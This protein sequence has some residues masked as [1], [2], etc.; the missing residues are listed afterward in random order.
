M[1]NLIFIVNHL[2]KGEGGS[3]LNI[4]LLYPL[5]WGEEF[6]SDHHSHP[7]RRKMHKFDLIYWI[8]SSLER[9]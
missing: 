5:M 4:P 9:V 1:L 6:H 2:G 3:S 8:A 7:D